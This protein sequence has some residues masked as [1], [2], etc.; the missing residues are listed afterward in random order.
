[1]NQGAGNKHG[2]GDAHDD[3]ALGARS[4]RRAFA[5]TGAGYDAVAVL[6][7]DVRESLL[8]RLDVTAVAPRVILDA[9]AV[10]GHASLALKRR[11]PIGV[12]IVL[13]P[14]FAILRH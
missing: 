2:A 9:G 3:F 13:D 14:A 5:R 1:M 10:T 7:T 6:Q 11:Y 4:V 12:V 8:Q